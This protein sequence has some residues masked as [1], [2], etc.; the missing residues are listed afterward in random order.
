MIHTNSIV[1][2]DL[3]NAFRNLL[4]LWG[5]HCRVRSRECNNRWDRHR[6]CPPYSTLK[7]NILYL[8]FKQLLEILDDEIITWMMTALLWDIETIL[9]VST[10]F[11]WLGATFQS[12]SMD[13]NSC[14]KYNQQQTNV[15]TSKHFSK[16]RQ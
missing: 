2:R 6:S 7:Y 3:G 10:S 12:T 4:L 1:G 13:G 8:N 15:Q 14:H 9:P 16:Y 5:I 11:V